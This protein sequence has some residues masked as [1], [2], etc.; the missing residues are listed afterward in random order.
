LAAD[1]QPNEKGAF[2]E[3]RAFFIAANR[4]KSL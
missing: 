3:D 4:K 1:R 2:R